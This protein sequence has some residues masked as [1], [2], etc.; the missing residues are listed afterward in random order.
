M[1]ERGSK[2]SAVAALTAVL[3]LWIAPHAGAAVTT[4]NITSPTDPTYA[5]SDDDSPN[6]ITIS[7]TS[8]GTTGDHVDIYC[9]ASPPLHSSAALNVAVQANG[10]FSAT[11]PS[12]VISAR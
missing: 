4:S 5:L 6:S 2:P 7:G 10:S 3:V 9:Y 8:D 1:A 12:S 11:A